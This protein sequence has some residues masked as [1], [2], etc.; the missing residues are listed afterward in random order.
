[1]GSY[2]LIMVSREEIFILLIRE[3]QLLADELLLTVRFVNP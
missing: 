2:D 1:M 3:K